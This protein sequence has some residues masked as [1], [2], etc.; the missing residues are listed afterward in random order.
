MPA[1]SL[2]GTFSSDERGGPLVEMAVL[3]LP[4]LIIVGVVIEGG[5]LLWRHQASLKA[6]RDSARYVSRAP[7]LFDED[8]ALDG[9]VLAARTAE[10]K[11]LGVT[12]SLDGGLPLVPGWTIADIDIPTPVVLRTDPCLA[13]V[14]A[15][16]D[17]E[18][19]VPSRR[20]SGWS[21]RA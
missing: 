11:L 8:C 2:I 14:Q 13:V 15:I 16:A 20:S 1:W 4:F 10:A 6:V 17:I 18:L 12:G 5:N 9:V 19:P 7:L 3:L 21:A